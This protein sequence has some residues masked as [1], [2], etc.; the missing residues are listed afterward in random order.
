MTLIEGQVEVV[1]WLCSSIAAADHEKQSQ[2]FTSF[3]ACCFPSANLP[4]FCLLIRL[5]ICTFAFSEATNC[6]SGPLSL[7]LSLSQSVA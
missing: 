6:S 2:A 7:S 5:F 1:W 3:A 4:L